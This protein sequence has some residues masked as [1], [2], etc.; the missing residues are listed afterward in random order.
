M[1]DGNPLAW[2]DAEGEVFEIV[3][4]CLLRYYKIKENFLEGHLF[5]AV[6]SASF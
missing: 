5:Y 2:D 1:K 3:R 6:T 4:I